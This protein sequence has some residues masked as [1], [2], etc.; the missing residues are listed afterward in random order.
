MKIEKI[1]IGEPYN[2]LNHEYYPNDFIVVPIYK[3]PKKS[4]FLAE[5]YKNDR[6][7]NKEWVSC[8]NIKDYYLTHLKFDSTIEEI[9]ERIL[10]KNVRIFH[11]IPRNDLT[12]VYNIQKIEINKI[13]G[14]QINIT[15]ID[16]NGEEIFSSFKRDQLTILEDL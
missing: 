15:G 4:I 5:I 16:K 13:N 10:Y 2:F 1:I 7:L 8:E 6:F 14:E 3:S 11:E 12:E 9:K